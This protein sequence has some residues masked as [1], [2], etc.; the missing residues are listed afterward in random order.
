MQV[1]GEEEPQEIQG[2]SEMDLEE[3]APQPL[4]VETLSSAASEAS[5]NM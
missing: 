4:P 5:V 2:V 1:D 3:Q